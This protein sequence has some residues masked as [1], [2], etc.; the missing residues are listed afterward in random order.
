[1]LKNQRVIKQNPV[2]IN[3]YDFDLTYGVAKT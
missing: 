1:M 2:A 3:D